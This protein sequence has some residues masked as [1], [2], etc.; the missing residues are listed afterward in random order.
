M[1]IFLFTEQLL[2]YLKAFFKR[3]NLSCP[4]F[5]IFNSG[6]SLLANTDKKDIVFLDIEMPVLNGIA[7]GRQINEELDNPPEIIYVTAFP[8]Y[9]L[10]AWNI[11]AFGYIL[12]PYDSKQISTVLNRVLR[13]HTSAVASLEAKTVCPRKII[14]TQL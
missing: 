2:T 1:M 11:G 8:E 7:L 4:N 10:E 9:S 6:E 12:K 5:L 13:Y 14:F 3:N